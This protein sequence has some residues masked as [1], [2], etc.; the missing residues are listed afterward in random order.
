MK[1]NVSFFLSSVMKRTSTTAV[2]GRQCSEQGIGWL[3]V[4]RKHL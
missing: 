2:R 4:H 1:Y 3:N